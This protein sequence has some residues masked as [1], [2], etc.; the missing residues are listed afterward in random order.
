VALVSKRQGDRIFVEGKFA[1]SNCGTTAS[2]SVCVNVATLD[3]VALSECTT[4]STF[5]RVTTLDATLAAAAAS[6]AYNLVQN[7]GGLPSL[8]LTNF[9]N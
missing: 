4:L 2:T 5:S 9:N 6:S 3:E 7:Y 1:D 8:S